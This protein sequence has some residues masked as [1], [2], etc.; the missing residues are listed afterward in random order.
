MSSIPTG[1]PVHRQ[2]V[3]SEGPSSVLKAHWKFAFTS[4]DADDDHAAY[5][6]CQEKS[7]DVYDGQPVHYHVVKLSKLTAVELVMVGYCCT[8]PGGHVPAKK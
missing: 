7:C 5:F 3:E 4:Y 1:V 6:Y 2:W 8:L